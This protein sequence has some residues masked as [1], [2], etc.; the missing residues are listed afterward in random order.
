[1]T[2]LEGGTHPIFENDTQKRSTQHDNS[3]VEQHSGNALSE[4]LRK[5]ESDLFLYFLTLFLC[6][7]F[8]PCPWR[9]HEQPT[10]CRLNI[11]NKQQ[12]QQQ[13]V[14]ALVRSCSEHTMLMPFRSGCTNGYI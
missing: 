1:M 10:V 4:R 2:P 13:L 8:D 5:P 14:F 3:K 12:Q 6:I 9:S 7:Y 11:Q